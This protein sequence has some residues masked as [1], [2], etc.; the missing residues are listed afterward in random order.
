MGD[1]ALMIA[2]PTSSSDWNSYNAARAGTSAVRPLTE[3]ALTALRATHQNLSGLRA[4]ELGSGAGIEARRLLQEG[5]TVHTIDVDASVEE[6]MHELTSL[7]ALEHRTGLI[8][9][10]DPLPLADLILANASLPFIPRAHFAPVWERLKQALLPGGILAVDLFGC[11]DTWAS[12]Q[13][14]YL[15]LQEVE[16]LLDALEVIELNE[17][18]EEGRSFDG[19]KH[20]H[21]FTVIARRPA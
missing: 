8:E 10:W 19:I 9:E 2:T 17:R 4:V 14:T 21:T 7:G 3:R 11:E 18:N 1:T 6:R 15:T 5:L 16:R 20:W 13:G 12:D